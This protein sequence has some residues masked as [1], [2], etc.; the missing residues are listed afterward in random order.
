M[1]CWLRNRDRTQPRF[2][3]YVDLL[4]WLRLTKLMLWYVTTQGGLTDDEGAW[5]HALAPGRVGPSHSY[6]FRLRVTSC[7]KAGVFQEIID[8]LVRV[9]SPPWEIDEVDV[10]SAPASPQYAPQDWHESDFSHEYDS[11][12]PSPCAPASASPPAPASAPASAPP[13][14]T[15]DD[16]IDSIGSNDSIVSMPV[17]T[18][19]AVLAVTTVLTVTTVL[20][21]LSGLSVCQY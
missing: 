3:D 10:L 6:L 18:V 9:S 4:D 7:M 8:E 11:P 2:V 16:S 20:S 21:V 13:A 19:M 12:P 15:P 5:L 1:F 17:W 14:A